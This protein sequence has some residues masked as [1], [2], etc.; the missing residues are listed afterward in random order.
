MRDRQ[1]VNKIIY[2]YYL[3]ELKYSLENMPM[4]I[5]DIP[6]FERNNPQCAINVFVYNNEPD[7]VDA[8][9]VKNPYIDVIYRS[10]NLE[11]VPINLLLLEKGNN[12]QYSV[13]I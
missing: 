9:I 13:Q 11:G 7:I 2:Q 12:Y 5:K 3:S 4:K 8:D 10:K 6:K 1:R